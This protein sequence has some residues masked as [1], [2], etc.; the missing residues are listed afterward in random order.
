[1]DGFSGA[2]YRRSHNRQVS[3]HPPKKLG[4]VVV[5]LSTTRQTPKT[6]LVAQSFSFQALLFKPNLF[7]VFANLRRMPCFNQSR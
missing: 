4:K 7:P 3:W 2:N 6:L 1:L 5:L